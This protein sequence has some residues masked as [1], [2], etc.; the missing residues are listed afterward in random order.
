MVCF[1]IF[2]NFVLFPFKSGVHL[3]AVSSTV[4]YS[5]IYLV[6]PLMMFTSAA[7]TLFFTVILLTLI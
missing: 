5:G 6:V 7:H 3:E 4:V 1:K 2:C